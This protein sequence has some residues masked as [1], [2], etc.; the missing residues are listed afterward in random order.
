M[1]ILKAHASQSYIPKTFETKS[2]K[3]ADPLTK[4]FQRV[5]L[6][7]HTVEMKIVANLKDNM[8]EM[9]ES[10][11]LT[12][13]IRNLGIMLELRLLVSNKIYGKL[14]VNRFKIPNYA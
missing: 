9:K 13:A 14:R 1:E 6:S 3:N 5:W 7:Q 11:P 8:T 12:K 2:L 10:Q 4:T